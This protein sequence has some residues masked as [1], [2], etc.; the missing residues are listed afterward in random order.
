[1][2]SSGDFT[3]SEFRKTEKRLSRREQHGMFKS[4]SKHVASIS[5]NSQ[6][7]GSQ[8]PQGSQGFS[9]IKL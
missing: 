8:E 4:Q 7:L 9:L 1:M 5:L 2:T 6:R 3:F